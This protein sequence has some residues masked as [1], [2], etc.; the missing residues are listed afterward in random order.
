MEQLYRQLDDRIRDEERQLEENRTMTENKEQLPTEKGAEEISKVE[1]SEKENQRQTEE[2]TKEMSNVMEDALRNKEIPEK[3][4]AEMSKLMEKLD[5]E[6]KEAMKKAA[7]KMSQAAAKPSQPGKSKDGQPSPPSTPPDG[8]QPPPPPSS[9]REEEMKEAMKE[10]EKAL[11]AMRQAAQDMSKSNENLMARNFYNR[12]RH[13]ASSERDIADSLKQ[14]ARKTLGL[15]PEELEP[16]S[17][18]LLGFVSGK[19][20]TTVKE[21]E[22]IQNDLV[23]YVQR[24]PNEKYDKVREEMEQKKVVPALGDLSGLVKDNLALKSAGQ[25]NAWSQQ[26][27]EWAKMLQDKAGGGGGGGGGQQDPEMMELA[28]AMMRLAQSEDNLREQTQALESQKAAN[29]AYADDALKLAE[30]QGDIQRQTTTISAATKFDEAK[31]ILDKA[32]YLMQESAVRLRKSDSAGETAG[33]QSTI[34]EI[35]APPAKDSPPS[36]NKSMAQMQQ[37]MQQMSQQMKAASTPGGNASQQA[38]NAAN[39]NQNGD[40]KGDK[41]NARQVDKASGSTSA[42]EWPEEYRDVLQSYF[43]NVEQK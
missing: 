10:Q 38:S 11:E 25:A 31:P 4:L 9:P 28:I 19:Q 5:K 1:Q 30:M 42:S 22:L 36:A 40:K 17:K 41:A 7:E 37:M 13:A 35:L 39:T 26:M 34:I 33:V 16:D 21:V 43:Q 23:T 6:A 12:L 29:P 20:T 18:K 24:V 27:D 32:A 14:L 15:K 2:L 3:T 8:A